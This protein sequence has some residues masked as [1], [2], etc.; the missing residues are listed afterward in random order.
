MGYTGFSAEKF[1][2]PFSAWEA[3][4]HLGWAVRKAGLVM[5]LSLGRPP[6]F[7]KKLSTQ[8]LS[9]RF[10]FGCRVPRLE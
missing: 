3:G 10:A 4:E 8:K 7:R 5:G 9:P 2:A 1:R 6:V